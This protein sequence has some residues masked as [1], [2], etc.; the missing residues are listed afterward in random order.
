MLKHVMKSWYAHNSNYKE[1]E[2]KVLKYMNKEE[3][4]DLMFFLKNLYNREIGIDSYVL[5]FDS[6]TNK[7][8]FISTPDWDTENEPTVGDSIC[9]WIDEDGEF[10]AK[11]IKGK[12]QIY[13]NKWQ[14]VKPNYSGFDVEAAKERTELWNSIPDIN[15][16]KSR[17]GYRSYWNQLLK[18]NE[19]SL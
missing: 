18:D 9:A 3:F 13:H 19:I 5:K 14:F 8:S 1:W 7:I 2:D 16:H 11:K 4:E 12:N 15:K 10:Q 6:L 17:I